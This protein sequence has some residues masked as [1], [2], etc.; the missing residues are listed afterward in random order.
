MYK[1]ALVEDEAPVRA[2]LSDSIR[3]E[4]QRQRTTVSVEQFD[5]GTRFLVSFEE[6]YHYDLIFLDIEM[7]GMDG[8]TVCRRIRALAPNALV[9]FVS[10]RE[11]LVF[12]TFEVQ[13]FRFIR[14]G[15]FEESLPG[16][17]KA[18]IRELTRRRAGQIFITEPGTGDIYSFD[19]SQ[20]LYVE[21]QRKDCRLVTPEGETTLR[22]TLGYLAD[23]LTPFHFIKSHRS[24]LVN[25]SAIFYIGKSSIILASKE[26][27]PISR[28]QLEAVKEQFLRWSTD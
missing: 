27:I 13:P 26:E 24:Y 11:S 25:C 14:K 10:S 7:P 9:V 3:Q 23:V 6:H 17:V 21:A 19:P 8:I 28:G 1:A 4:F 2:F 18:L 12:D 5:S 20:L 15:L 22:C 16:L